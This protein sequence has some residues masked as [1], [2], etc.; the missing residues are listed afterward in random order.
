M[1]IAVHET[2]AS[3]ETIQ[4]G[5]VEAN[6][7]SRESLALTLAAQPGFKV[8]LSV[9]SADEISVKHQL[10][11]VLLFSCRY[12]SDVFGEGLTLDYWR[13]RLPGTRIAVL[14]QTQARAPISTMMAEGIDAYAIHGRVATQQLMEVLRTSCTGIQA[15]C[16]TAQT[17]LAQ[18]KAEA[19]L[20]LREMQVMRMLHEHPQLSRKQMAARLQLS[21]HTLNV[22]MRN[23]SEK[24]EVFGENAMVRRCIELGWLAE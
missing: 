4:V 13:M 17:I 12:P 15:F 10:L 19:Q 22:H 1:Q 16:R 7:L 3:L 2:E 8:S 20:T 18:G 21:Y 5:L 24:L 9:A 11:D 14:T 23:I 6:A